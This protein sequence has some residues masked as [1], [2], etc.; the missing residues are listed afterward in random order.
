MKFKFSF[1]SAV[2]SALVTVKLFL[3]GKKVVSVTV[4]RSFRGKKR[5]N[6]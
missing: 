5:I 2:K 6:Q 3:S 1:L 4:K